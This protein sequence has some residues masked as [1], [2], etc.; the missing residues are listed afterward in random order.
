MGV[1]GPY[2]CNDESFDVLISDIKPEDLPGHI[3]ATLGTPYLAE[4]EIQPNPI[5]G[6]VMS[7]KA[8]K[9][10]VLVTLPV[11]ARGRSVATHFILDTGA[12]H[13]YVALSVLTALG[14]PEVSLARE[15]VRVNGVKASLTVS[16]TA[17]VP[18]NNGDH[19]MEQPCHFVGLNIL[20][21]DFLDRAGIKLE[22][23]MQTNCVIFSS[24]LF[25]QG[26]SSGLDY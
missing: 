11:S 8:N 13:S 14:V 5:R 23:D 10:R 12:S 22:I 4:M 25:P 7:T 17:K 6:S 16:D 9:L 1:L 19:A 21:M 15:V 26:F 3:S 18:Y 2:P 24:S 20:G